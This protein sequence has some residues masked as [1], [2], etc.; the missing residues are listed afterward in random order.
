MSKTKIPTSPTE[1]VCAVDDDCN[2]AIYVNG[3]LFD[4]STTLYLCDIVSA[5]KGKPV[6]LRQL[7]CSPPGTSWPRTLAALL[8]LEHD[9]SLNPPVGLP[10]RK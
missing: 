1:I 8:K 7:N 4:Y 2:E 6:V 10:K 5:A 9:W 3:K